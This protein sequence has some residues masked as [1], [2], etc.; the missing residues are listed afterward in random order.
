MAYNPVNNSVF[1]TEEVA[2]GADVA[3]LNDNIEDTRSRVSQNEADIAAA[4][5]EAGFI[6]AEIDY[7]LSGSTATVTAG[8]NS[9]NMTLSATT[10]NSTATSVDIRLEYGQSINQTA[11]F[12]VQPKSFIIGDAALPY[13]SSNSG[14]T[15]RYEK[16]GGGNITNKKF[17]ISVFYDRTLI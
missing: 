16:T 12:F 14:C 15:F 8:L 17:S 9:D 3:Q 1:S 11:I 5:F 13:A 6:T 2:D 4:A 7:T 10:T